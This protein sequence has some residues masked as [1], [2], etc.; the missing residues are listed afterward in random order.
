MSEK[1]KKRIKKVQQALEKRLMLDAAAIFAAVD[2]I[3]DGVFHLDAQD[4]DGDNNFSAAC[5]WKLRCKLG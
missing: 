5:R 4:I 2:A 1:G 3:P